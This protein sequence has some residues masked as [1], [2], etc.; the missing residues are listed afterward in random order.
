MKAVR[1]GNRELAE[2]L[3]PKTDR[4]FGTRALL[5]AV[6]RQDTPMV[7][8]LLEHG[9]KCDFEDSDAPRL[10]LMG[11]MGVPCSSWNLVWTISY[12]LL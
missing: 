3:A 4:V 6:N 10:A 9:I 2:I 7:K 1:I 12:R 8:L 5:L 11:T